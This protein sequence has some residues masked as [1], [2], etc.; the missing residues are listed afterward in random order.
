MRFDLAGL[1]IDSKTSEQQSKY[2]VFGTY[3]RRSNMSTWGSG[4]VLCVRLI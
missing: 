2:V 1:A 4:T 3:N